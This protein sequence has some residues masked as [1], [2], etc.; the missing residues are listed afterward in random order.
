[1]TS[2][3][4]L[5][6]L[7][8]ITAAQVYA[9][10]NGVDTVL[11]DVATKANLLLD[12]K[13]P[14]VSTAKGRDAL[15]S[16]AYLVVRSKTA[17]DD[18]G[19]D[20][21]ANLKKAAAAV[22]ADR[23]IIRDKLD[24]LATSI[25]QPVVDWE[26]AEKRRQDEL[27]TA[28]E[29][30]KRLDELP[31]NFTPADV[32]EAMKAVEL[33]AQREWGEFAERADDLVARHRRYLPLQ[34][35]AALQ[36]EADQEELARLREQ[37]AQRDREDAERRQREAAEQAERDRQADLQAAA[38]RGRQAEAAAAQAAIA[39]AE[40]DREAAENARIAAERREQE[41]VEAERKRVA[42]LAAEEARAAE[43]R[44]KDRK[45]RAKIHMEAAE[46]LAFV[47]VNAD[48]NHKAE[49]VVKAIAAGKIPHVTI[50]Y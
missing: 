27:L 29:A 26:A 24:D 38:E 48:R 40:R 37:Q 2:T 49:A 50:T 46:E 15:K 19:K 47:I 22:D 1:M 23:R 5:I 33:A 39:Q 44:E 34:R 30:L 28:L 18:L 9:T 41:A 8:T 7:E 17:L 10:P 21:V 4:S 32:D 35:A 25:K 36:R 3:T 45:H 14:D 31:H 42:D 11:A 12:E 13:K 6:P 16:I 20:H 43:A